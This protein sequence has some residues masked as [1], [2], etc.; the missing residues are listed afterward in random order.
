MLSPAASRALHAG[1]LLTVQY[2]PVANAVASAL[3]DTVV[4]GQ[5]TAVAHH[6]ACHPRP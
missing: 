3:G 2:L 1:A 5:V 4:L 6:V